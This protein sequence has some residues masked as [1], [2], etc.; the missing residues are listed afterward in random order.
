M[1]S[2]SS[3]NERRGTSGAPQDY[4]PEIKSSRPEAKE[5]QMRLHEETNTLPRTS[6]FGRRNSTSTG[7]T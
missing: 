5:F 2:S 6:H 7:K 1:T 4:F 3:G